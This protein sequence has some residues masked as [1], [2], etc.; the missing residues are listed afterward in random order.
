MTA[1]ACGRTVLGAA[2]GVERNL[3]SERYRP[4]FVDHC[5]VNRASIRQLPAAAMVA[6]PGQGIVNDAYVEERFHGPNGEIVPSVIDAVDVDHVV[7]GW[8]GLYG[9][10]L[11][12]LGVLIWCASTPTLWPFWEASGMAGHYGLAIYGTPQVHVV[13]SV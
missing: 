3:G 13:S 11:E 12:V 4:G 5:Q 2:G 9:V 6:K 1:M 7:A 10:L 8:E